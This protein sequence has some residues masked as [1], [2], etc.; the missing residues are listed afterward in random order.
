VRKFG[1]QVGGTA[2]GHPEA[3]G[4]LPAQWPSQSGL[5]P[6]HL[7]QVTVTLYGGSSQEGDQG[8]PVRFESKADFYASK[9]ASHGC[10]RQT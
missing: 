3:T 4:W 9:C 6:G 5:W 2:A 8:E 7:A 1:P 10:S